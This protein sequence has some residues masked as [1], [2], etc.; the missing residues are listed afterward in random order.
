MLKILKTLKRSTFCFGV[1]LGLATTTSWAS[2]IGGDTNSIIGGDT[3]SIV[4]GDLNSIIGSEFAAVGPIDSVDLRKN[5]IVVLGQAFV[6]DQTTRLNVAGRFSTSGI[7]GLRL[8]RV[9]DY[10][11]I[12]G[13]VN[14]GA[15]AK[16]TEIFAA[17]NR[18][19]DGASQ[20][21]VKGK[22]ASLN[23]VLGQLTIGSLLVDFTPVLSSFDAS[24][25]AVGETVEFAGIR[26]NPNGG[27]VAFTIRAPD[28]NS[29]IGGDT[30]SI[31]GGDTKSIIGGDT[32][33]IIGGD[34]KSI[35]GGDTK[36]IIGGDTK[37]IIGGD[38]KSIIGGDTKSIIGGDT[39][40]IIGGDTK[41]IIGGDTKSII[42][43]DAKSI[44][45]GDTKSIIGGD[46]R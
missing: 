43:G 41:S 42:G 31:I 14:T 29:I 8:L 45:G 1:I 22:I 33:S 36:S 26:P 32:K 15:S 7:K 39:K 4:G 21:Y 13:V 11:A 34:T 27:L 46:A 16:A 9:G 38:T 23:P 2:I 30:K 28:T 25:L 37:S 12:G 5:L 44:I 40:S 18:Y 20:T 24:S 10:V 6:L 19:V 35:I 3:R 17:V